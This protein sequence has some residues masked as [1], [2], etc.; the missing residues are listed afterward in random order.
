M[1]TT[2]CPYCG[3]KQSATGALGDL[4]RCVA[5]TKP[6]EIGQKP[7]LKPKPQPTQATAE[8]AP[9]AQHRPVNVDMEQTQFA[10]GLSVAKFIEYTG[11]F[12]LLIALV[13]LLSGLFFGEAIVALVSSVGF[14]LAGANMVLFGHMAKATMKT[15]DHTKIIA[16]IL[17]QRGL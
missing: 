7:K 14:I 15:A 13:V 11:Y 5:C 4:V 6:F 10:G 9:Q 12:L 8:T 16:E 1:E 17:K 3:E 2:L